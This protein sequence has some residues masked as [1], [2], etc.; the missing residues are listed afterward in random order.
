MSLLVPCL[1]PRLGPLSLFIPASAIQGRTKSQQLTGLQ[2]TRPSSQLRMS[3]F[4]PKIHSHLLT[5]VQSPDLHGAA[6]LSVPLHWTVPKAEARPICFPSPSEPRR[7][8][9]EYW[10]HRGKKNREV[11]SSTLFSRPRLFFLFSCFVICFGRPSTRPIL[12]LGIQLF[13]FDSFCP[14]PPA[15]L[16]LRLSIVNRALSFSSFVSSPP[17][18]CVFGGETRRRALDRPITHP[19]E[20]FDLRAEP[21]ACLLACLLVLSRTAAD[22]CCCSSL[23]SPHT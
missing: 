1:R 4:W 22:C 17:P 2:L 13:L 3:W 19:D 10:R 12:S 9:A 20:H 15:R 6:T 16:P 5:W 18:C 11:Q 23:L 7:T 8:T 21:V 14:I